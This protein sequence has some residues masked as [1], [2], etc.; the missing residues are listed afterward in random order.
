MY[1]L[2]LIRLNQLTKVFENTEVNSFMLSGDIEKELAYHKA[3]FSQIESVLNMKR[4]EHKIIQVENTD[5]TKIW[6]YYIFKIN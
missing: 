6:F 2:T 5:E 1:V 4:G 3:D